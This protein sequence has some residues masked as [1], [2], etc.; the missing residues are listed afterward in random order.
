MQ[1]FFHNDVSHIPQKTFLLFLRSTTKA[2]SRLLKHEYSNVAITA[3]FKCCSHITINSFLLIRMQ[4]IF[5]DGKF[6]NSCKHN[7]IPFKP[8]FDKNQ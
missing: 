2:V 5:P 6:P 3:T 4:Y 8:F 7:K 1:A